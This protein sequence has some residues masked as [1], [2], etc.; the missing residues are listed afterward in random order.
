MMMKMR[1][2]LAGNPTLKNENINLLISAKHFVRFFSPICPLTVVFEWRS[3]RHYNP[4]HILLFS[5]LSIQSCP[6]HGQRNGH[7]PDQKKCRRSSSSGWVMVEKAGGVGRY[8]WWEWSQ[9]AKDSAPRGF[10]IQDYNS[11]HLVKA[12]MQSL[13]RGGWGKKI[14]T[15]ACKNK[16]KSLACRGQMTYS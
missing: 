9:G 7:D 4:C 15:L 3:Y 11:P 10:N 16:S 2:M 13:C 8:Y 5:S 12:A 1:M 14:E 6:N